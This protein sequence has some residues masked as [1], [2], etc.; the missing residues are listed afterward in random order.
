MSATI[1]GL[2][3]GR[4]T[5]CEEAWLSNMQESGVTSIGSASKGTSQGYDSRLSYCT[6]NIPA[7]LVKLATGVL[8]EPP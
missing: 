6:T 2:W 8:I 7:R 3:I 4:E 5:L 1:L